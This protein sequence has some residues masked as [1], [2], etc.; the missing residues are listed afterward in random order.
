MSDAK[1]KIKLRPAEGTKIKVKA[2]SIQSALQ[3]LAI[4]RSKIDEGEQ[5]EVGN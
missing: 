2:D 1:V 4:A 5:A 3:K